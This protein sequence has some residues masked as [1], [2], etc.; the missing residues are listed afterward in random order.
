MK[1]NYFLL[2]ITI[3]ILKYKFIFRTF[4]RCKTAVDSKSGDSNTP[5]ISSPTSNNMD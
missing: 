2:S 4:V 5:S 1:K 3:Y